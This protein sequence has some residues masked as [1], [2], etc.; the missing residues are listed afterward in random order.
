MFA[1]AAPNN[2]PPPSLVRRTPRSPGPSI[3]S[4]AAIP[5][6]EPSPLPAT[7][8]RLPLF[9]PP[10]QSPFRPPAQLIP[11]PSERATS[12]FSIRLPAS[13]PSIPHPSMSAPSASP[14]PAAISSAALKSFLQASLSPQLT[15]PRPNSPPPERPPPSVSSQFQSA[16]PTQ[17]RASPTASIFKSLP[18]RKPA[19]AVE[20]R[21]AQ[22][23]V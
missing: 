21:S 7:T 23:Q 5:R 18:L 15:S 13:L 3:T 19:R 12:P 6:T 14:L 16:I 17:A 20:W 9:L 11:Q 2:S 22:V 8:Q 4:P 10:T 1:P